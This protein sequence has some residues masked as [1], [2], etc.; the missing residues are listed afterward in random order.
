M[1]AMKNLDGSKMALEGCKEMVYEL[2]FIVQVEISYIVT[3]CKKINKKIE[4]HRNIHKYAR[5]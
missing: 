1:I 2:D 5:K 4:I 3:T